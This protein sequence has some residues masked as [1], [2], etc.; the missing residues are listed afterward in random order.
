MRCHCVDQRKGIVNPF[1][2]K[3]RGVA[4]CFGA[5]IFFVKSITRI[6]G[7]K[8][9]IFVLKSLSARHDE[10]PFDRPF[11]SRAAFLLLE[12]LCGNHY[13]SHASCFRCFP[14]LRM[15]LD[16]VERRSTFVASG[17]LLHDGHSLLT[18]A[19]AICFFCRICSC[20]L[21]VSA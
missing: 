6:W 12:A 20:E 5:S 9:K 11:L 10:L 3:S 8:S 16:D 7:Q 2:L 19:R 4:S 14:A 13:S 1:Y 17:L 18:R 15:Q 21:D